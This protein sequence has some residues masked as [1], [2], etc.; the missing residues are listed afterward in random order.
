MQ[1][2]IKIRRTQQCPRCGL[3]YSLDEEV[4]PHCTGLTDEQVEALKHR[5]AAEGPGEKNLG[6]LFIYIAALIIVGMLIY[7]LR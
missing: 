5:Y 2:P 7:N 4:C 3:N 6:L 1:L